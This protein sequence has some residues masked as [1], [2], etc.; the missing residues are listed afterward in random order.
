MTQ[1][2]GTPYEVYWNN[3][4]IDLSSYVG[5][6]PFK[7]LLLDWNSGISEDMEVYD[8]ESYQSHRLNADWFTCDV[9]Y[10]RYNRKSAA[11]TIATLPNVN[12][13]EANNII[14]K[15]EAGSATNEG[16]INTMTEEELAP[17]VAKGWTVA[18]S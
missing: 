11:N 9:A 1:E 3:Q 10:S 7:E 13:G 14:F 6:L 16:A 18:Y 17:A 12:Q 8:D 5:W 15:G 4:V 2:D